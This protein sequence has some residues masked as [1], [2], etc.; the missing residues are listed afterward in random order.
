LAT[1][2][3]PLTPKIVGRSQKNVIKTST[4]EAGSED[5]LV[6]Q[7]SKQP[8][9]SCSAL[10]STGRELRQVCKKCKLSTF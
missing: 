9:S 4:P 5:V 2:G 8:E 10:G 6:D 7:L 3:V 1:L